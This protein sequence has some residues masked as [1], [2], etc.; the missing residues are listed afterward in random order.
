[1]GPPTLNQFV[2]AILV[3][4][5]YFGVVVF[6]CHTLYMKLRG[7]APKPNQTVIVEGKPVSALAEWEARDTRLQRAMIGLG[8]FLGLLL[9]LILP[10]LARNFP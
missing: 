9:P 4:I 7:Q 2:I 3:W 10:W 5:V 8:L 1:V 6:V